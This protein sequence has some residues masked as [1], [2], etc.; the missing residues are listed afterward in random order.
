[1]AHH[2]VVWGALGAMS[3]LRLVQKVLVPVLVRTFSI[4]GG[5]VMSGATRKAA[6]PKGAAEDIPRTPG[7]SPSTPTSS[8]NF[9]SI[10]SAALKAYEK[11]TKNDLLAHPLAARLQACNS[12]GDI[13]VVLQ[14]EVRLFD[15]SRS[16][17]E[18]L[19][20]W[21]NPTINVLY[22]FSAT[23]G[24]GV[25]LVF[26]PAKVIFAGVGVLLLAA[27]DIEASQDDLVDLFGRIE[28]FFIRLESYTTVRPTDAM[29][30]IIVKIMVEVLNIFA[31]ATKEMRQGRAKKYLKKLI[32]KKEIEDALKRLDKLTQEEARMAAAEILRLTHVVDNKVTTVVNDGKETKQAVQQLASSVDDMKCL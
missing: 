28:N 15:Q 16:A 10:F 20:R 1:M 6:W 8:S 25:G 29:T 18:R 27:K 3:D 32:G 17:D 13:L 11:K 31:I 9:R 5:E 23:L 26:S 4:W 30:D 21:L 24:E 7:R 2:N 19:S 14:D 12:P 22:T